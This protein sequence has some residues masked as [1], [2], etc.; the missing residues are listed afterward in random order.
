MRHDT[1]GHGSKLEIDSSASYMF[2]SQGLEVD[3]GENEREPIT[4]LDRPLTAYIEL[5]ASS[6]DGPVIS[7]E[8]SADGLMMCV[9]VAGYRDH[10]AKAMMIDSHA[11]I[12]LL[13]EQF[14]AQIFK[15]EFNRAYLNILR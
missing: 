8:R 2:A 12:M 14:N 9:D 1:R 3:L 5:G 6:L 13:G 7:M 10:F 11:A 4:M 15:L